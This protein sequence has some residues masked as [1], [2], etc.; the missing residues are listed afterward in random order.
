MIERGL[1][2]SF[3]KGTSQL[4]FQYYSDVINI[5]ISINLNHYACK[6]SNVMLIIL[7]FLLAMS[8]ASPFIRIYFQILIINNYP[9]DQSLGEGFEIKITGISTFPESFQTF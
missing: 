7:V 4:D 5:T 8:F 3:F 9:T 6:R 1:K 2:F